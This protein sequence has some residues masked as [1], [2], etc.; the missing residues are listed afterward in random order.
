MTNSDSA[1]SS[2]IVSIQM[3]KEGFSL[4]DKCSIQEF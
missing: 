2:I 3:A 1:N 4:E